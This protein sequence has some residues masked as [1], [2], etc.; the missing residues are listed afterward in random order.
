MASLYHQFLLPKMIPLILHILIF[1]N[2][3][4]NVNISIKAKAISPEAYKL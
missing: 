4:L 1:N 3:A 2:I